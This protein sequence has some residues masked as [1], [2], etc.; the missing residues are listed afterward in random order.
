VNENCNIA[1][2]GEPILRQIAKEV[3]DINSKHIQDT[4][5]K[6]LVCVKR[7]KGV[8]LAAPQIFEPYQILVISSAPNERYPNAPLMKDEVLI[9]PKIISKS[10]EKQKDWEGCLSIP[11]IRALV[12]RY[13]KVEVEYKT[14]N[15]S[16]KRV[17]FEDFIARIFQHEYD[18]L[19]GK[20][21]IDR[22][23]DTKDIVSEEIYFRTILS[24]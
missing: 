4:I 12:P 18:H 14:I 11:G 6:M 3:E 2:L 21:Y 5:N 10:E 15:N 13:T 22:V 20:V 19:I 7:S 16:I 17:V 1:K 24:R 9:N 8:G 23:E